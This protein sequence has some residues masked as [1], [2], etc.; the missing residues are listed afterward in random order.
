M[1]E[2]KSPTSLQDAA[3]NPFSFAVSKTR[4]ADGLVVVLSEYW[5]E[6]IDEGEYGDRSVQEILASDRPAA[7][8]AQDGLAEA[9]G[10]DYSLSLI[11]SER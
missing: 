1:T 11:S 7:Q 4:D 2:F 5:F 3:G 6:G 8:A 10:P 9:L